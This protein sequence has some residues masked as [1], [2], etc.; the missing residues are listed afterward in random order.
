MSRNERK[1][2]EVVERIESAG[3]STPLIIV[4]DITVD[5]E[6]II[7]ETINHFG[8]LDILINNAGVQSHN[9]ILNWLN[10]IVS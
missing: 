2:N 10:M 4:A 7:D 1:L 8:K 5:A 6:R 9:K 3:F